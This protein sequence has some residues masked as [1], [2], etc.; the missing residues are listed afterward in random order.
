MKKVFN[1]KRGIKSLLAIG[2]LSFSMTTP[3]MATNTPQVKNYPLQMDIQSAMQQIEKNTNYKFFYSDELINS[4]KQTTLNDYTQEPI[5]KV[6]EDLLDDSGLTYSI[7]GNNIVVRQVNE[8]ELATTQQNQDRKIQGIIKDENGFELVGVSVVVKGTS[9][10]TI[11][12][13]D[14]K[15]ELKVSDKETQLVISYVGFMTQNVDIRN[16][17]NLNITLKEDTK[18]LDEVVVVGYT[19]QRKADLTGAVASVKMENIKDMNASNFNSTLQGRMSG[20]TVLQSSGAPGSGTSI[21][22][23]GLG[24]FGN[25]EPL[26]VID[27][28]L[29][30]NMNDIN[31]SDIERV[32]VLKDASSAAIYGSRAANGVVII[33]TK[34]GSSDGK[35][36]VT[37]NT[38]H[39]FSS[40]QKKISLLNAQERNLIHTEALQNS[41]ADGLISQDD[42]DKRSAYYSTPFAKEN[43]T[44]W[45]DEVF[46][47]HAYTGNYDLSVAGSSKKSRYNIM[48]AHTDQDGILKNTNFTRTTFRVN[49]EVD[50]TDRLTI[51]ENLMISTSKQKYVTE[52]GRSGAIGAALLADPSV[53]I[54]GEDGYYSGSGALQA[55]IT[56]PVGVINRSDRKF[57]RDKIFGN[58]YAQYSIGDFTLK[59]DFGYDW[60]TWKDKWFNPMAPEAGSG[61]L[62]NDLTEYTEK[63]R[64]WINTTTL[65]F[66]KNLEN[67]R[68]MALGGT[69]YENQRTDYTDIR[70][71]GF[72]SEDPSQRYLEAASKTEWATGS[73]YEHAMQS[74]FARLDYTFADRYLFSANFRADGS[75]RFKSGNRWGYFP[76]FSGGWR[77]SE[78]KFFTNLKDKAIQNLKL[79][80]SWGQLGNENISSYYPTYDIYRGTSDD[81]GY[82]MVF[83]EKEGPVDGRYLSSLGNADLKW[84]TTTQTDFGIDLTFLN[85]F[86]LEFDY[87][88]KKSND[89]LL[90]TS[91]PGYMGVPSSYMINAADVQNKGFELNLSYTTQINDLYLNAYGNFSKVKN[92]VTSLGGDAQSIMKSSYRGQNIT[93]IAEGEPIGHFYGYKTNGIFKSQEEI[94]NYVGPKGDLIQPDAKVGDLIFVDL[95]GDGEISSKDKTNIGSGFPD[96]TY[97]FGADLN[98]KNFDLSMFFQGVSGYKIFNALKYE[99][100]FVDTRYNQFSGIMDRFHPEKNPNGST[101][102]V[103]VKDT[104]G[105][106]NMSDF[107]VDKGDY[108]RLKT[109]T[110]GYTLDKNLSQKI[111]INKLRFYVTLQNL[112]TIT[113]YKGFDPEIGESFA[114]P[115]NKSSKASNEIGVDRGQ[116]PQPRTFIMGVNINF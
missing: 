7:V 95:D 67:H 68:I 111:H 31:P 52:M 33:Q 100:M 21:R 64:R 61:R 86:N 42:F 47:D 50:V 45:L 114:N 62:V 108:L 12:D 110:L 72:L 41:L 57:D 53:P 80:L 10:G 88:I 87:F 116:F 32:D 16:K 8:K 28:M 27:G 11:T 23:R 81:D 73:R 17:S 101:P 83:G 98:W 84:E 106:Q 14:G 20:V 40:P 63:N 22:I 99:G 93:R 113:S 65:K 76:S 70:R 103:T 38:S 94:N 78:E 2:M 109:L 55:D 79:R 24:T 69:S 96:F 107:Y 9:Q 1:C 102:R 90:P 92:K 54:Y 89:V 115:A 13:L 30:D 6:V 19:T 35:V 3:I 104:N 39:G 75:S 112:F 34:K 56:N 4:N 37:F 15:F 97:G 82:W 60:L 51:G 29:T 105:N 44:N 49:T 77:V 91:L 48:G 59:T 25:N 46:K 26:Y 74:F 85:N 66:E 18:T 5:E 43:R 58:A 71:S 36:N